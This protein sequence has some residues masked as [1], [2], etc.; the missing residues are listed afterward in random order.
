MSSILFR[1][2]FFVLLSVLVFGFSIVV[3]VE[4]FI[5]WRNTYSELKDSWKMEAYVRSMTF[6]TSETE[7]LVEWRKQI[8]PNYRQ[9]ALSSIIQSVNNRL[10]KSYSEKI[11][12]FVDQELEYRKFLNQKLDVLREKIIW[13]LYLVIVCF[14]VVTI[15]MTIY[16]QGTI[17][18]PLNSLYLRMLDFL[19]DRYTYEFQAPEANEI[20]D[21]QST[22][23]SLAQRVINN[24]EELKTLDSAKTEFLNIASHE[25]RTP[26]TSIK[27]S[28][29]LLRNGV[30]GT[31]NENSSKLLFIAET[32]TDRLI[33]LINDLLDLAKIEAKKLPLEEK[34]YPIESLIAETFESLQGLSR[35]TQVTLGIKEQLPIDIYIDRDRIHQ[36]L[37]NLLSNAIKYSPNQGSVTVNYFVNGHHQLVLEV[38]DQGKGIAPEDQKQIFEKF[39]QATNDRNPLV[40]G[41]GLG[42]AIARAIIEE[43]GGEIGVKS[44]PKKGST[45]YFTLPKWKYRK[46]KP[47]VAA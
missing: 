33:R 16:I 28:L 39:R 37:T 5:D 34:W 31:L 36:V 41:T 6:K 45:F 44:Q 3:C 2:R 20:G 8:K 1:I 46:S 22:F 18:N 12:F 47:G 10:T 11:K 4:S 25:L 27:G 19:N 26:L 38:S 43:H 21:L 40:K 17:F 29:S 30:S 9:D 23:N 32:E 24:I 14:I 7:I 15:F 13:C 42:L 35:A